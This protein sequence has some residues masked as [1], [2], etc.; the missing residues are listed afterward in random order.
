MLRLVGIPS[1]E[2]R[3]HSYPHQLS[4]GMRQ[5]VVIAIALACNPELLI[6]D[7]PTTALDVTIQAQIL[8]LMR[9][10][11]KELGMSLI[12]ITH[13]LGVIADMCDNVIV[14]YCGQIVES[15][16]MAEVF[17][18][19]AHPYTEGL[20]SSIP[21][22]SDDSEYLNTI[23]GIVPSLYNLPTGCRFNPRCPYATDRCRAEMPDLYEVSEGHFSR[24]FR[25]EK[26]QEG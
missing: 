13:D 26:K 1:P 25:C 20:M 19:Q 18:H 11:Q 22:M 5:R 15:G 3:M 7:E 12:M 4:G 2:T 21:H 14:M 10:L 17:D 16:T 8:E 6:A 24:C 23:E 9:R